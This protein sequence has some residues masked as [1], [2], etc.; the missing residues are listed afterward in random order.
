MH[1]TVDLGTVDLG[2]ADLARRERHEL[3]RRQELEKR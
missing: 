3:R 2:A 1:D